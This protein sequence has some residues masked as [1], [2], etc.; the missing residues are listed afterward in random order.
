MQE[1]FWNDEYKTG[2]EIVDH[3]HRALMEMYNQLLAQLNEEGDFRASLDQ[4]LQGLFDY[5]QT[6]FD[7]E[8]QLMKASHYDDFEK[9]REEHEHLTSQVFAL[10]QKKGEGIDYLGVMSFIFNWLQHHI[11]KTDKKFGTYYL[12]NVR[13][14]D[15]GLRNS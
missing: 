13:L 10:Y 1:L 6:H 12:Q 4:A 5:V 8:E 15:Q 9:H 11:L 2:I 14:Q 3:Q 7:T